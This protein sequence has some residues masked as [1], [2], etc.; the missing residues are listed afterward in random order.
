[1]SEEREEIQSI[2]CRAC[3]EI[4]TS[5]AQFCAHCGR[6]LEEK[7]DVDK[8]QI[9]EGTVGGVIFI[10]VLI[11]GLIYVL[12]GHSSKDSDSSVKPST[13][14]SSE[15]TT[16]PSLSSSSPVKKLGFVP[17]TE[18]VKEARRIVHKAEEVGLVYKIDLQLQSVWVDSDL[19]NLLTYDVK[20]VYALSFAYFISDE[21][22]TTKNISWIGI[23]DKYTGKEIAS[24]GS[25]WGFRVKN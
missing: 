15:T 4:N 5:G 17:T 18:Q 23:R 1:M 7:S 3:R 6:S 14:F 9:S 12:F 2:T 10:V 19:W 21:N 24:Y 11:F 16:T 13:P 20:E 22:S 25:T 8:K